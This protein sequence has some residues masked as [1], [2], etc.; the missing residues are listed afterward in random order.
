[1]VYI[2]NVE[3]INTI[4]QYIDKLNNLSIFYF[5][6]VFNIVSS[7]KCLIICKPMIITIYY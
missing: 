5:T 2:Y 4:N 3:E 7:S 1:M 6:R